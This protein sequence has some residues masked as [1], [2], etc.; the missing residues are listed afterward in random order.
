MDVFLAT[1]LSYPRTP[2]GCEIEYVLAA[3]ERDWH[4]PVKSI[5][6]SLVWKGQFVSDS[7][8]LAKPIALFPLPNFATVTICT[9]VAG[10]AFTEPRPEGTVL[11]LEGT[12]QWPFAKLLSSSILANVAVD[13]AGRTL[14]VFGPLCEA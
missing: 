14:N 8:A 6:F 13:G 12:G 5:P 10:V 7:A 11:D 9:F 3:L 2:A 4:F 1:S